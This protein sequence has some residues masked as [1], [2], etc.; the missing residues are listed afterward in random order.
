MGKVAKNL[1][2]LMERHNVTAAQVCK[3]ASVPKSSMSEWLSGREPKL[4][5]ALV[6]VARYFDVTVDY[7]ISGETTEDLLVKKVV[8][9]LEEKFIMLH[10]GEYR[11]TLE[12]KVPAKRNKE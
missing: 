12:K 10:Q 6:R 9:A 2:A 3:A 11:V 1:R 7:F 5:E 8:G 4:S